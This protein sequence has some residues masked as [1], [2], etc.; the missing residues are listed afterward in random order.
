M[1]AL[2]IKALSGLVFVTVAIGAILFLS[3]GTLDYPEGWV[4]LL[5]FSG[6]SAAITLYFL[7]R[8]PDLIKRRVK[9]GPTAEREKTQK[10]IQ[11][12]ANVVFALGV[13]VPGLD[14]RFQ[15]SHVPLSMIVLGDIVVALGFLAVFLVF[16]ENTFTS[17]IIEVDAGQKVITTG[18][19][20]LIRHPMYSGALAM[21][22]FAPIALG[23]YWGLLTT[24]PM[25]VVIIWRLLDEEKFLS[26][27]LSGYREYCGITR[28]RLIPRI[29]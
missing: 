22:L 19:Y 16:K 26:E 27:H 20:R 2:W 10:A 8:D 28:F 11:S 15:W 13:V 23:S 7:R 24:V 1:N 17:A 12:V 25:F 4:Y 6:S 9:A 5:I 3:A 29:W 18:P 14:H 21:I